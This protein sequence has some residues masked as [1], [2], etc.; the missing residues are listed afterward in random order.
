[1]SFPMGKGV[2]RLKKIAV[3]AWLVFVSPSS[4]VCFPLNPAQV[5]VRKLKEDSKA[6]L[7]LWE[8]MLGSLW[9]PGPGFDVIKHLQWEQAIREFTIIRWFMC[10]R[11]MS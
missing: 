2:Y 11:V 10:T 5:P 9:I 8:T 6:G 7:E 3:L 1:M 4:S